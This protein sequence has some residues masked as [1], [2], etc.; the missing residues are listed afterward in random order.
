MIELK[1]RVQ[2]EQTRQQKGARRAAILE[3]MHKMFPEMDTLRWYAF[4]RPL[5]RRL[6]EL[7]QEAEA[8]RLTEIA[9]T[10]THEM[11]ALP[12]LAAQWWLAE[13]EEQPA[14]VEEPERNTDEVEASPRD[15]RKLSTEHFIE[16]E[17]RAVVVL[18]GA[19]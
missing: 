6:A 1:K 16:T 19:R 3:A 13:D 9:K 11:Q 5:F 14:T 12:R 4:S 15:T 2:Q 10:E 7:Q 8:L 17:K 18:P